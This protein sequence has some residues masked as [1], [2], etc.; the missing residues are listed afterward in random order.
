MAIGTTRQ[1]VDQVALAKSAKA[2]PNFENEEEH[3]KFV[4]PFKWVALDIGN[5]RLFRVNWLSSLLSILVLWIFVVLALVSPE[6]TVTEFSKWQSWVAQN[7]TWL[8]IGTQN[9]WAILLIYLAFSRFGSLKLGK[10]DEKPA[11]DY[12]AWF[13]MLFCCGIGVGIYFWGVSEPMYY[14]RGGPLWRTNMDSDDDRAQQAIFM[15]FFHW[16]LHGFVVYIV[17]ALALGL[18][19]YRWDMPLTMRSAFYPLVGNLIYGTLGD[20]IDALSIACTTF[21]VCT[22]L[23]FGVSSINAGLARLDPD[24]FTSDDKDTQIILIIII[25]FLATLSIISGLDRGIQGLSMLTFVIGGFLC[26]A[27]LLMDNTWFLLNTYVQSIGHYIQWVIQVGFQCDAW[28][29]LGYEF[30]EFGG[31]NRLWGSR[32]RDNGIVATVTDALGHGLESQ[33][34]FYENSHAKQYTEWWTVF[35]WGWWISWAPFVGMFIARIS[36]GRTVREVVVGAFVAPTLFV[37]AWLTIFGGLGI[38]MERVAELALAGDP[39]GNDHIDFRDGKIN[40]T[41]F[42]YPLGSS[43]EGKGLEAQKLAD[44]G[45]YLL[46]CRSHGDR[47]YD[48]LSP[49]TEMK[50]FFWALAVIGVTLYFITS[51]D[52]GSYVDDIIAAQGMPNPPVIQKIF[53]ACTEGACAIGLIEAGG[54]DAL[55]ALQAASICAGLPYTFAICFLCTA[56]Y[57]GLKIDMGDD[58]ICNSP[59]F[60]TGILDIFDLFMPTGDIKI[61]FSIQ[62]RMQSLVMGIFAPF[63]GVFKVAEAVYGQGLFAMAY[64]GFAGFQWLMWICLLMAGIEHVNYGYLGWTFYICFAMQLAHLRASLRAKY[65]IYGAFAEDFFTS[66]MMYPFVISQAELQLLKPADAAPADAA[67]APAKSSA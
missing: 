24:A 1:V 11:Y 54:S 20:I 12:I 58:D 50:K 17:V 7:W 29:Q 52:S 26:V 25:T 63:I 49:Y 43:N 53:W 13:A 44:E 60:S 5:I 62:Q 40:C 10:P 45:Y 32:R 47:L 59:E 35:Y 65:E 46:A 16:G 33:S 55:S 30:D 22:S 41:A 19:A 8:Y 4:R 66:L 14:Y 18:V 64:A 21:G 3:K 6:R 9:V 23:G 27:L 28:Q 42:G 51:S 39:Y 48:M 37:F 2:P 38:K 61:P 56:L 67:A 34:S 57:R 31:S 15:T 36:R